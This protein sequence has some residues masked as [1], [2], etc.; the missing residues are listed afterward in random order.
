[1]TALYG[2]PSG[3]PFLVGEFSMPWNGSGTF[4]RIFSWVADKAA[5]LDISSSRMDTDTNDLA[6]AGF[7]NCLTRDGQGQPTANLPMAG[8]RHTG[9]QNAVNRTDY[10]AFGQIQDGLPN[11]T[12]AGGS[13]DAITATYTP[14]L[15]S[16]SD[17]QLCFFRATAPNAT[18]TPTFAPNGLTA[19]TITKYGGTALGPADIP[20]NLAESI[21]RYNVSNTRWE[22]LN[23]ANT[24]STGI[25]Q[26]T[27]A[28]TPTPGWLMFDDG[29]FGSATSG[30]SNSNSAANQALFTLFFNNISDANSPLLTS[31]GAATTRASQ[32]SAAA[33]WAANCRMS[34]NKTLGRAMAVAGAGSGL[35][36]R[37]LGQVVGEENHTLSAAE[38]PSINSAG[39]NGLS[40]SG[41]N[42]ITVNGGGGSIPITTTGGVTVGNAAAGAGGVDV[43]GMTGS[44]WTQF[45]GMS[46]TNTINVSGSNT[47]NVT[48][49]NTGG[50]GHNTM[51]P[52][53]FFNAMIKQ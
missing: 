1:M 26:L 22:L 24:A 28:T 39:S 38:I 30:S 19:R 20:G 33:A 50:G 51:Q 36:A 12:I 27:I 25:V 52:T 6:S 2:A 42:N 41:S 3:A 23:P 37:A 32:G 5:G 47:I 48:S 13:A 10:A 34:L 49:N 43:P 9:V 14:A 8:F 21:L 11:W 17:G 15:T 35:T 16:L 44:N 46:G 18:T 7:G 53:A 4:N 45:T 40:L 29:T 31:T